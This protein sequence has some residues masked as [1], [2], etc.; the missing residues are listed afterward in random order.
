MRNVGFLTDSPSH[1]CRERGSRRGRES[2]RGGEREG[3][4][5]THTNSS[6]TTVV[7]TP[8]AGAVTLP[9]R[10]TTG[11][12]VIC[13]AL[14]GQVELVQML[15][16]P[17]GRVPMR[18]ATR[19][20]IGEAETRYLG[21]PPRIVGDVGPV[22]GGSLLLEVALKSRSPMLG[23]GGR[24]RGFVED[25]TGYEEAPPMLRIGV[26]PSGA[27]PLLMTR[28]EADERQRA[29]RA[30]IAAAAAEATEGGEKPAW[31]TQSGGGIQALKAGVGGLD[32]QVRQII[33]RA[34]LTRTLPA[35]TMRWGRTR[36]IF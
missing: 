29:E 21:G 25:A 28:Q 13:K 8:L 7:L 15:G 36:R 5:D 26:P 34:F 6:H 27:E 16:D 11:T 20:K 10:H 3:E 32:D 30:K 24:M 35:G 14:F 4:G 31:W 17:H 18:Q 2:E 22:G 12:L 19:T 23:D 33:R 1:T 9:W